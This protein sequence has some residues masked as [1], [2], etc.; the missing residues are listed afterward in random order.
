MNSG[1]QAAPPPI[2]PPPILSAPPA[3][4]PRTAGTANADVV[5][6]T[7]SAKLPASAATGGL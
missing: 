7:L 2:L 5:P 4:L 6:T 1:I 3:E